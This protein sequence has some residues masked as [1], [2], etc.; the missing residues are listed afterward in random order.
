M[1]LLSSADTVRKAVKNAGRLKEILGAATRF[2][3]GTLVARLPIAGYKA[4]S[5]DGE[6]ARP[7]P[8]RLRMLF[9]GLGPTFIKTGQILAGRPDLVPAEI[10]AEF[11]KLQDRTTP[12]P[13]TLLK[14][15]LEKELDRTLADCF[16]SFDTEPLATASIAQV[17]AARTLE[18]DDVVVKIRKPDVQRLLEQDMEILE[19]LAGLIERYVPELKP[20]RP[21]SIVQEFKRSLLAETDFRMEVSSIRRFRENFA[22]SS[23]LVVPKVYADLSSDHV[24]T[25]ERLRGVPL[26]DIEGVRAMGV[27]PRDLLRQGMDCFFQSIMQDGLFHADPHAGNIIALPDGRMGLIDFGSVGRLSQRSKDAIINMFLALVTEDYDALILEYLD[28]S[29]ATDGSRST[30]NIERIQREVAQ[31]MGPYHGVPLSEI[32]TGR[33]LM[34]STRV[35]FR[36]HVSLPRDLVLVFKAIMTLEGIGRALDPD[37]DLLGAAS[38]YSRVLIKER[39]NPTRLL[40]DVLFMS[41]DLA[42]LA[43]TGPRQLNEALRQL[44]SGELK[45]NLKLAGIDHHARAQE[46]GAKRIALAILSLAL[47]L[48]ATMLLGREGVPL[49]L[50][51]VMATIAGFTATYTF[52]RSWR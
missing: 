14:P 8:V 2:G 33:V 51:I 26:R 50:Q 11:E 34:E 38:K 41:R 9:E 32:P 13:F 19:F 49:W 3:F 48:S 29:P 16:S 5:A 1:S 21:V 44:E 24:I 37:F 17:H 7:L 45:L 46:Q 23:F 42:R 35:A 20:F 4:E 43:K 31:L 40:K 10:I 39:Y 25:M 52:L 6:D 15:V 18:G 30:S 36:Y 22:A 27:D 12:V 47:I 28:L